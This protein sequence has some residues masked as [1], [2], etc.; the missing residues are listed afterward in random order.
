MTQL[1]MLYSC[2]LDQLLV[3]YLKL[4]LLPQSLVWVLGFGT[5]HSVLNYLGGDQGCSVT[6][7]RASGLSSNQD[8]VG[9]SGKGIL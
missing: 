5:N 7:A 4:S 9:E 8:D 1:Q 3:G 2:W 6:S